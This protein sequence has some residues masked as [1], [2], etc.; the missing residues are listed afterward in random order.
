MVITRSQKRE[1]RVF[2]QRKPFQ[3]FRLQPHV[4]PYYV[5][6]YI[7]SLAGKLLVEQVCT[8]QINPFLGLG[9]L[10]KLPIPMFSHDKMNTI[11]QAIAVKVQEAYAARQD[12]A[13]LLEH[14]KQRVEALI[15]GS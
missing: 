11:G 3:L 5:A 13:A 1:C 15:L 10:K 4:H 2:F 9:N 8:G 7:N 6:G 14:A 12:A